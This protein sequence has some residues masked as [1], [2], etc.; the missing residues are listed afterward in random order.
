M[1]DLPVLVEGSL[2][3]FLGVNLNKADLANKDKE[4]LSVNLCGIGP[5]TYLSIAWNKITH[6]QIF[7]E[8]I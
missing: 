2:L 3:L 6:K 7:V 1:V 8:M 5:H 4:S